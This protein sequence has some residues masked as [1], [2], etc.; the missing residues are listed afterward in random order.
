[1]SN[2]LKLCCGQISSEITEGENDERAEK[3]IHEMHFV[4]PGSLSEPDDGYC[5]ERGKRRCT[6]APISS[7]WGSLTQQTRIGEAADAS[8][9]LLR[10]AEG[11]GA[12]VCLEKAVCAITCQIGRA[13]V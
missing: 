2:R 13:H 8:L 7:K 6:I 9:G 1:M 3:K 12:C 11:A 4:G 5:Q 10:A